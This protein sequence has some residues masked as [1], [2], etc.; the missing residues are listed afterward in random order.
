MP[1]LHVA[2]YSTSEMSQMTEMVAIRRENMHKDTM[3]RCAV[4]QNVSRLTDDNASPVD[5]SGPLE[6]QYL[7]LVIYTPSVDS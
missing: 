2:I 5:I 7:E 1:Y 6:V 3:C 4:W